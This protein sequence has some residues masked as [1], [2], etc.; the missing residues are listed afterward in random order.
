MKSILTSCILTSIHIVDAVL[1]LLLSRWLLELSTPEKDIKWL[2]RQ[3]IYQE[4]KRLNFYRGM[5]YIH[6]VRA[7]RL[8]SS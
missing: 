5:E 2:K 6:Q 8:L 1:T 4:C 3:K 7:K